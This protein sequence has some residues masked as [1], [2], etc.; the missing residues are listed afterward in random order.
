M[1]QSFNILIK[2][3]SELSET[4]RTAWAAFRAGNPQIYSPYFHIDY[5]A[6]IAELRDDVF[7]ACLY[8]NDL[9]VGFLPYQGERFAR[10][11]GAPMT[12]YHG[13]ICREDTVI[14][15]VEVLKASGIGAFH[16]S[17]VVNSQMD[18]QIQNEEDGVLLS[19]NDG[20]EA[21]RRERDG[22]YRRHLKS[23][24]RRTRKA[25]EDIGEP[26]FVWK[27]QDQA[28]FK[29]LISWKKQKF[30]ETGKYD[31]LSADWTMELLERLWKRPDETLRCDM[32]ALYFGER[33]AA[34]DLGLSDGATFHSWIVAYDGELHSYAPGIQ[35]LEGL[36]DAS[37]SLGYKRIDLGVGTDGYKRH[38]ATDPVKTGSG[39]IAAQ[40]PAAALS[41]LYGKAESFGQKALGD[42]PGKL[43]RRYTQIA[44]CE[45][46]VS[47]RAKAMLQAVKSSA[48]S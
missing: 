47:G 20:A 40:G 42:A 44:A 48:R 12:D 41:N 17:A 22:S 4:D 10:P 13:F 30:A 34:I 45:D 27:S 28:V 21:W 23:N 19:L 15:P 16:F 31:V 2:R 18:P 3:A 39:F 9:P 26:R 29:Q 1:G 24:R 6:L 46:S 32:Q 37:E 43:R 7:I 38:Y 8:E 33:L 35:L 11:V 36:I 5:T 14:D 25:S